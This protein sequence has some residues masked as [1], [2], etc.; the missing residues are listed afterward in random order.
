MIGIFAATHFRIK[1]L[2]AAVIVYTNAN[3]KR[4]SNFT[5]HFVD[6]KIAVREKGKRDIVGLFKIADL[7]GSVAGPDTQQF[8]F[9][10]QTFIAFNFAKHFVDRG[11]LPL[12]EGSVHAKYL[13][14]NDI[15]F[16]FWN[17]EGLFADDPQIFLMIIIFGD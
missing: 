3:K 13:N 17:G 4:C 16:N 12:T 2:V 1:D 10:L 7:K 5:D 6:G 14:D 15:G 9:A 11:S 8:N